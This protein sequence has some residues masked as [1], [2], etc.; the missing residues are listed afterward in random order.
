MSVSIIQVPSLYTPAYNQQA[1]LVSG[2]NYPSGN[3]K[4][5]AKV[6]N[7]ASTVIA[8]LK[9]PT[10]PIYPKVTAFDIHRVV[11]NYVSHTVDITIDRPAIATNNIFGFTVEFGEEYGTPP[12]EHYGSWETGTQYVINTALSP[13]EWLSF[14]YTDF[15]QNVG[16]TYDGRFLCKYRGT[17]KV[18]R[19]SKGFLY[20]IN[21][22][23][24]YYASVTY[25]PYDAAGNAITVFGYSVKIP[26]TGDAAGQI[27]YGPAGVANINSIPQSQIISGTSGQLIPANAAYYKIYLNRYTGAVTSEY[28]RFDIV[29]ASCKYTNYSKRQAG[30]TVQHRSTGH[31]HIE[32]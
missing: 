28:L 2:T 25:M 31:R 4:L 7:L 30:D 8:K 27:I 23:S 15:I 26:F 19:T 6:K 24:N 5:I 29:D 13:K 22:A 32:Y 3:Y 21:D 16:G 18:F 14:D 10:N 20:A 12:T 9:L 17:R 11:E 1:Y